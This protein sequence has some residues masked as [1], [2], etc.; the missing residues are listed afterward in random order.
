MCCNQLA[1]ELMSVAHLV[2]DAIEHIV[3]DHIQVFK[4]VEKLHERLVF[5]QIRLHDCAQSKRTCEKQ[6]WWEKDWPSKVKKRG[7]WTA[8][9]N[10]FSSYREHHKFES[11]SCVGRDQVLINKGATRLEGRR[12]GLSREP[13]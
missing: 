2:G 1:S 3:H 9:H 13:H 11:A 6:R 12:A 7:R 10:S 4:G 5:S 8:R